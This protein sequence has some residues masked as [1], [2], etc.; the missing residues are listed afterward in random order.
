M[1]QDY[2]IEKWRSN[3]KNEIHYFL[4][5]QKEVYIFGFNPKFISPAKLKKILAIIKLDKLK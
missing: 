3:Q 4:K 5:N 2:H 1:A